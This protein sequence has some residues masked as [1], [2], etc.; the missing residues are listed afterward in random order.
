MRRPYA[1]FARPTPRP[2]W[3]CPR[4]RMQSLRGCIPFYGRVPEPHALG[5]LTQPEPTTPAG[6]TEPTRGDLGGDAVSCQWGLHDHTC[7]RIP[8]GPNSPRG[9][10]RWAGDSLPGTRAREILNLIGCCTP[11]SP[12]LIRRR[13]EPGHRA[14]LMWSNGIV[15]PPTGKRP[16]PYWSKSSAMSK[17]GSTLVIIRSAPRPAWSP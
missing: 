15:F 1:V 14:M 11:A 5:E 7:H 9:G 2:R 10:S 16:N 4:I 3:Y 17:N 8:V 6:G 12:A 13:P